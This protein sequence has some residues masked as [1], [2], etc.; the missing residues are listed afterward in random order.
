MSQKTWEEELEAAADAFGARWQRE[1]SINALGMARAGLLETELFNSKFLECEHKNWEP[2]TTMV[3]MRCENCG[4]GQKLV[5]A[6]EEI[7]RLLGEER[8]E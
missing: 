6:L 4:A 8:G 7:N 1:L 2:N 5:K 3:L